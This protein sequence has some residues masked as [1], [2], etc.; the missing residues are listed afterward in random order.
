MGGVVEVDGFELGQGQ[1]L[2]TLQGVHRLYQRVTPGADN[3]DFAEAFTHQCGLAVGIAG[4]GDES[5]VEIDHD[6]TRVEPMIIGIV[7]DVLVAIEGVFL[8]PIDHL[9]DPVEELPRV[10]DA[11]CIQK[12]KA[13]FGCPD[14]ERQAC[15][16][17]FACIAL[18]QFQAGQRRGRRY[19]GRQV[20][21]DQVVSDCNRK[22]FGK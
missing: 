6:K 1:G 20:G 14:L 15:R 13:E 4:V 12:V 8:F 21:T 5:L 17:A 9:F 7:D 2:A 18:A 16:E 3:Q 19:I 10:I 22:A 11:P